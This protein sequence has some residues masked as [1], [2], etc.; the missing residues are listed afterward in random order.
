MP[1][2]RL[3][4]AVLALAPLALAAAVVPGVSAGTTTTAVDPV[5]LHQRLVGA[6][7]YAGVSDD[8]EPP[9]PPVREQ[10]AAEAPNIVLITTD[11]QTAADMRFMPRTRRLLGRAGATFE[12]AI[13]PHPLCCPARAEIVSGQFAQNNGVYSNGGE[14]GGYRRLKD[15]HNTL[16]KWLYESGYHT[17]MVG[18]F[19]THWKPQRDGVPTGWEWFDV[20]RTSTFGYYDFK[21]F[22]Q[23]RKKRY[24]DGRAYSSTYTTDRTVELIESWSQGSNPAQPDAEPEAE[25]KPFFIWSSYFAPH[26]EC[27]EGSCKNGPTPERKYA[28]ARRNA[29]APSLKKRSYDAPQHR[30]NPLVAGR[31]VASRGHT[32]KFFLDR[33]R[34]LQSVDEGVARIV[35]SLREAGEL[36]N[37][38]IMFTSDNGYLLGEHR[39]S[40]KIVPYEEA[41]RVPLLVRGPGIERSRPT[42]T[43]TTVDL[44]PTIASLAGATPGRRQDGRDLVP[45]LTGGT[46]PTGDTTLVQAGARSARDGTGAWMYRGVRT[47]DYTFTKW[48]KR[49]GRPFA[50]LFDRRA[51]PQQLRNVA[52]QPRYRKVRRELERRLSKLNRCGGATA[53][54]RDFGRV[55]RPRR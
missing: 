2:P 30:P 3:R 50:E 15:P 46:R 21:M 1:V 4:S 5:Q 19:I 26:G 38:V 25:P 47:A 18:K 22:T 51:D 7:M 49:S 42:W 20:P 13:S 52:A 24:N 39:Y 17:G 36:S 27:G 41:L 23:G 48:K 40:G 45:A 6:A 35:T 34:S 8:Y 31:K 55:P 9:L 33:V 11:D 53:C 43:A 16:P 32:Q 12:D 28:D 29:K 54:F 14:Y 37:T 10:A 44:A